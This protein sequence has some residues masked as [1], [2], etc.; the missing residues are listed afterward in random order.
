MCGIQDVVLIF[1]LSFCI[2]TSFCLS[3]FV[4]L[5]LWRNLVYFLKIIEFQRHHRLINKHRHQHKSNG[6]LEPRQH[7][8]PFLTWKLNVKQATPMC[9]SYFSLHTI[10][11][12]KNPNKEHPSPP[13]SHKLSKTNYRLVF[14]FFLSSTAPSWVPSGGSGNRYVSLSLIKRYLSNYWIG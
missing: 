5:V 7:S 13:S 12:K 8:T 3:L 2:P 10:M 1:F 6:Q 11:R 9:T 4:F 14:Y